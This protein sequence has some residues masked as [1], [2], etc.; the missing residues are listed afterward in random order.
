MYGGKKNSKDT[1][2]RLDSQTHLRFLDHC[3]EGGS[4]AEFCRKEG[5][6]RSTFDNW[7]HHYPRMKK[8]RE[9][10]RIIAEGWWLEQARK[11]L[12][13]EKDGPKLN[14]NLYKFIVGGRFGH[15]SEADLL[16]RLKEIEERMMQINAST[17]V[18]AYAAEAECEVLHDS[19]A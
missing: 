15:T 11:H 12:I 17:P 5:I 4:V 16:K 3:K 14:T 7:C 1:Q 13:E 9:D 18:S 10:G 2:L 8:A 19:E 6:G